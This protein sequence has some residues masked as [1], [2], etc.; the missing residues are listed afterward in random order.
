MSTTINTVKIDESEFKEL[1]KELIENSMNGDDSPFTEMKEVLKDELDNATDLDDAQKAGIYSTFLRETFSEVNRQAMSTA[2]EVLKTNASFTLER[3]N[4]EANYN[5][6]MEDIRGK[7]ENTKILAK[8]AILKD[9]EL[10][11]AEIKKVNDTLAGLKLKAELKKQYGVEETHEITIGNGDDKY[12]PI[13]RDGVIYWYMVND[14]GK[15]IATQ[16][17]C[18]RVNEENDNDDA[19]FGTYTTTDYNVAVRGHASTTAIGSTVTNTV[20]PGAIDKQIQGYDQLDKKDLVK[21]LDEMYSMLINA[22][23]TEN[24]EWI[25]LSIKEL[26]HSLSPTVLTREVVEYVAG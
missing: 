5:A 7:E 10:E 3:Y 13:V 12:T 26:L 1:T 17:E 16:E 20:E 2:L 11:L 9:K 18:D 25:A 22:D 24:T 8:N 6:A 23:S 14:S 21:T 4:V 15:F 19:V